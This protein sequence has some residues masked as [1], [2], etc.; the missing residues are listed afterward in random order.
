MTV[1]RDKK[2]LKELVEAKKIFDELGL[3]E[4]AG[5]AEK[6]SS[7]LRRQPD[8]EVRTLF[9]ISQIINSILDLQ[10]LLEKIMDLVIETLGAERGL[11]ILFDRATGEP[12]PVVARNLEKETITDALKYSAGVV[13]EAEKGKAFLSTD[14]GADERFKDF[15][16]VLLYQIK[17]FMCVPLRIRDTVQGTVYV[18]S[19]KLT[20]LFDDEDLE[21]LQAFANQAAVAIENARL[22]ER[23]REENVLLKESIGKRYG[24]EN[25]I[26]DSPKMER[27][28][29]TLRKVLDSSSSLLILGESGT[30]KELIAKAIHYNGP[31]KDNHFVALNCA[32]IPKELLESEL[33][34]YARGAFSGAVSEKKGLLELAHGGT[35]FFD[36][37]GE[38]DPALQAKVLRAIEEGVVRRIGETRTRDTEF[39]LICATNQ[40]LK[41]LVKRGKF[42]QD[43][44][45]RINVVP[46][47]I[48]PLRER[49]EDIPALVNAF[50]KNLNQKLRRNISGL[51]KEAL[52]CLERYDWPGNVRELENVLERAMVL[53]DSERIDR[54]DLPEE[55]AAGAAVAHPGS[56]SEALPRAIFEAMVEGRKDFWEAVRKP[57]LEREISREDVRSV[58]KLGLEKTGGNYKRLAELFHVGRQY[59]KFHSFLKNSRCHLER[60]E[61]SREK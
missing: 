18:D 16:S 11:I 3:K 13:R 24:F 28:F 1:E 54:A 49:K 19:R 41:D 9:E 46:V 10:P 25:I 39:R 55:I 42:R 38:M 29:R 48:P 56:R 45:F 15:K 7:R 37:I 53:T 40:D 20:T 57:F 5:E 52:L 61:F 12:K 51:S 30:G 35:F 47:E 26:G 6:V 14:A 22:Y 32:A 34:G 2:T 27:V 50:I 31:R 60:D 17:S 33:F 23:L 21:F 44:Y 8:K 59:K 43:L 36:E 58:I 4:E